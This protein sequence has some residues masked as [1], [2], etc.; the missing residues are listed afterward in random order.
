MKGQCLA[1]WLLVLLAFGVPVKAQVAT[2]REAQVPETLA[3]ADIRLVVDISGSMART[4]PDNLRRPALSLLV[5]LL[6]P[7]SRAGVWTFGGSVNTL[8]PHE[9]ADA[10]WKAHALTRVDDI[11]SVALY[12]HIGAAL[13]EAAYDRALLK[14][15]GRR[16]D[17]ILLTDGMVDV[18]PDAAVSAREQQRVVNTLVP[19]LRAAGYRVH[20]IGLSDEADEDLLRQIARTSDGLFSR[21]RN[22]EDLMN[23][24]LLIFQQTVPADQLPINDGFFLIDK[25][26]QEFT[27]LIRREPGQTPT[28]LIDPKNREYRYPSELANMN[29]HHT[30]DYDLITVTEPLPGRWKIQADMQPFS[31]LTVISDL[32]LVVEPVPNN[33]HVGEDLP[34]R[35]HLR[36]DN[37]VIDQPEVLDL[38]TVTVEIRGP[39]DEVIF[40][41]S[42]PKTSPADGVYE[43]ALPAP[44]RPG[45]YDVR[46]TLD[47][48]T[49]SRLYAH[50]LAV[51]SQ[52][53]V[54]FTKR[55]EQ[56]QVIW[57]LVVD[58][59]DTL[60]PEQTS[61]VAHVRNSGG[62]SSV[63]ALEPVERGLWRLELTP[64]QRGHYRISLKASGRTLEGKRFEE[65]LPSQ[66]F[67]YPEADD[68]QPDPVGEAIEN[69]EGQ[70]EAQREAAE[71][72]R[73]G[74]A[75]EAPVS[76]T[77][78]SNLDE[79]EPTAQ[80]QAEKPS[81]SQSE[82]T[83]PAVLVGSL[84]LANGLL[85]VL[86]YLAYRIIV[87]ER[88]ASP[89]L[90]EDAPTDAADTAEGEP[91]LMQSIDTES[92]PPPPKDKD[93]SA[94][95]TGDSFDL[96]N[97]DPLFPLSDEDDDEPRQ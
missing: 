21:A 18:S 9:Q 45:E 86:A 81:T 54:S 33:V 67:S 51:A 87:G 32:K 78:L 83:H 30:E 34:L 91:P 62:E 93:E 13:E 95:E 56:D 59:K 85:L 12:T 64:E 42:G 82:P 38:L 1:L 96:E 90:E 70:L 28:R 8:I 76:S 5:R 74:E 75:T 41:R 79:P 2:E 60:N 36:D 10:G 46:L 61:L 89:D 31:R 29:W 35:F 15:E 57:T 55:H 37:G 72:A 63:K 69:E 68:P 19:K 52:F 49:F 43:L 16:A 39:E 47:G 94:P 48:K 40:Q 14:E 88:K 7:D 71:I 77:T 53:D 20:T 97:E 27:A 11:N 25:S 80:P 50:Q 6:P 66:Y 23:S 3:P 58:G 26:V 92:A 84:V 73:R 24:L 44:E 22:A 17:I 4:D 65:H